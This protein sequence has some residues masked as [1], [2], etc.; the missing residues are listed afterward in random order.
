MNT[1]KQI[2]VIVALIFMSIVATGA[3]WMWDPSRADRGKDEQLEATR[4]RGAYLLSANCRICHGDS[5][6][7]GQKANRLREA[8]A[9]NR[10]DLQGRESEGAEADPQAKAQQY[11]LVFNTIDCG[12][13][14]KAMPTW[15]QSNGGTLNDEQ[16]RQLST[17][18]TE[19]TAWEEAGEFAL[20]GYPPGGVHGDAEVPF[21]LTE[22]ISEV[23]DLIRLSE[24]DSLAVG[25]RLQFA[26]EIVVITAVDK[27]GS[28]ITVERGVGTTSAIAHPIDVV[29]LKVPVPPE[30]AA[31]T[32]AACGQIPG[33]TGPTATPE[34]ATDTLTITSQGSL[35]DKAELRA[36]AAVPLTLTHDNK[37]DGVSHNWELYASEQAVADGEDPIAGTDIE[38]GPVVQTLNF[39]PLDAGEYYYQCVVHPGTMF[40]TLTVEAGGASAPAPAE[41]PPATP[42]AD[43]APA[44]EATPVP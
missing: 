5:G 3:Y 40:G 7:G 44:P 37:D 17:F 42:V 25:E 43:E 30:P 10:P 34:P 6:E 32:Q 22:P 14:G 28:T 24:S 13:V 36:L 16:M 2:N 29:I 11:K 12:R 19:G 15:G 20:H 33:A 26:E 38:A 9:L 21:T 35:F 8:P 39:G 1:S 23:S 18:I 31:I 4:A 41:T 27:E